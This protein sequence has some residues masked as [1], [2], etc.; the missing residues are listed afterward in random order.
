MSAV[1]TIPFITPSDI[2]GELNDELLQD[3]LQSI[4]VG[5]TGMSGTLVI[6]RFQQN[7]PDMP[8]LDVT[9]AAIGLTKKSRWTFAFE[10][11]FPST[12]GGQPSTSKVIRE[13][14]LWVLT[15][16][17]GPNGDAMSELFSMGFQIATNRQAMQQLGF[18]F[19]ESMDSIPRPDMINEQ[20]RVV[21]DVE[22]RVR[23]RQ[24]YT[25][26]VQ[27]FT[28]VGVVIILDDPT[29]SFTITVPP[30]QAQ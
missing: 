26:A 2:D 21:Y 6:P 23:R 15:S 11:H 20:N 19:I 13:E 7:P 24:G 30:P 28:S 22:F 3:G 14:D 18:A 9:W 1:N 27:E 10:K 25:Y 16:F 12:V 5:L 17:F 8:G 29:Q 4:V